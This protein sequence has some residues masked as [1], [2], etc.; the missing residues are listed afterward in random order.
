V[1]GR[2]QDVFEYVPELAGVID[3]AQPFTAWE[4][5]RPYGGG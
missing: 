1:P 4:T 3:L 5:L 2:R